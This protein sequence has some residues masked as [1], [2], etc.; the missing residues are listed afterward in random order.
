MV[1]YNAQY[2]TSRKQM[3]FMIDAIRKSLGLQLDDFSRSLQD[4][5]RRESPESSFAHYVFYRTNSQIPFT[6]ANDIDIATLEKSRLTQ[7]PTIA[8]VGYGLACG[9]QFS[10]SFL[11]IWTKGLA[12][13]SGRETFPSDRASFFYRPTELLGIVLGVSH[14]YKNKT[15]ESEWLQKILI[16]GEKRS[17]HSD[18]W[19]FLISAYAANILSVT[20]K[21]RSL[22]LVNEMTLDELALA[23]WLCAVDSNFSSRFGLNQME[24][25]INKS[26]LEKCT[27]FSVSTQG[28]SHTALL[29][30]ALK[31]TIN[32]FIQLCWDDFE[33]IHCNPQTAIEWLSN[34]CNNIHA[35]TQ[36]LKSHFSKESTSETPNIRTMKA[37]KQLL[38]RLHS[39]VSLLETEISEQIGMCSNLFIGI[40]QGNVNTG[41]QVI[42]TNNQESATTNTTKIDASYANIGFVN[43][44]SGA[45]SNFSQNIGQNNDEITNLVS[46]L[47]EMAQQ[48]PEDQRQEAL[49][50]L[51]DLQEDIAHP[52]KQKPERIK[53][54]LGRLVSIAGTIAG[55]VAG[56]ADFSNNV[57]ELHEKLGFPVPIELNH[58]QLNHQL[59]LLPSN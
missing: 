14:Y 52:D 53:I 39:D 42:M 20:W 31:I 46:S 29:H 18:L 24:Q 4:D 5:Y 19:T 23:K 6:V 50:T 58:S 2:Q 59:P 35:A 7:A 8:A 11:E 34:T 40:N 41:D 54:R 27:E 51:D 36:Y 3:V 32:Q 48:F 1:T 43:S 33:K 21:P 45:V 9:R 37:L 57:L 15:E 25:A 30:F 22:P 16:E 55:L 56:T 38:S 26:L 28:I 12:R 17:I 13:L 47:R 10:E 49:V 44:G